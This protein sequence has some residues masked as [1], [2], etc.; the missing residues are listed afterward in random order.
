MKLLLDPEKLI[1]D[2]DA[3]AMEQA[4]NVEAEEREV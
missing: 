1:N 4:N 2:E 3:S